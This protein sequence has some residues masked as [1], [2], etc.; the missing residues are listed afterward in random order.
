[1]GAA[2]ICGGGL[3]GCD[4]EEASL[5]RHEWLQGGV[6]QRL[7]TLAEQHGGF[8]ASMREVNERFHNLYWAGQDQNWEFAAYQ[9]EHMLEALEAG[10]QRRPERAESAQHFLRNVIPDTQESIEARNL[11][12]F[13]ER[14]KTMV[15]NCNTCHALEN[16]P[17]IP[18]SLPR[19]RS[20][21]MASIP[22]AP[23][24]NVEE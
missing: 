18:V 20:P 9:L 3:V 1:M 11:S 8:S 7:N 12:F 22:A 17:W 16:V 24:E 23:A 6:D 2:I 5:S 10:L 13:N 19:S 14:I 21:L 4:R 15:N